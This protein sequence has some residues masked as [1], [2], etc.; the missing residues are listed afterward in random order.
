MWQENPDRSWWEEIL[1]TCPKEWAA[2]RYV[3]DEYGIELDAFLGG[4][5]GGKD[6]HE[7]VDIRDC[8]LEIGELE[9]AKLED[10]IIDRLRNGWDTLAAWFERETE[11]EGLCR[12]INGINHL[13]DEYGR[14]TF[15][16]EVELAPNGFSSD[17][18]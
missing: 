4:L 8:H 2:I 18:R 5:A 7:V 9:E 1:L 15:E 3:L 16:I 10:S 12:R 17:W 6:W 11:S 13:V 14:E